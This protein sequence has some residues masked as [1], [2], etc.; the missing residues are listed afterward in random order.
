MTIL[1]LTPH[2]LTIL[3]KDGVEKSGPTLVADAAS[4]VVL[5]TIPRSGQVAR[6]SVSHV[7]AEPIDGIPTQ[8]TTYGQVVDLP[9][10]ADGV[11]YVVSGLVKSAATERSD[12]LVPGGQVRCRDNASKILGCLAL[13]R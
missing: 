1:N 4:A 9:E 11:F 7:D 8:A 13:N 2:D 3:A 6:V 12:L 10:P 5:R